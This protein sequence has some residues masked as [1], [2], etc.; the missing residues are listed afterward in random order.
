MSRKLEETIS[1]LKRA[2]NQFQKDIEQK[3]KIENMRSEFLG[4]V[5]R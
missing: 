5:S 3:E 4:N 2:N 1:E